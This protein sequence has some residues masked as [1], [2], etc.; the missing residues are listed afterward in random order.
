MKI[1]MKRPRDPVLVILAGVILLSMAVAAYNALFLCGG[2]INSEFKAY[3]LTAFS[4][5]TGLFAS[6]VALVGGLYAF[7]YY[8]NR[9]Q[10]IIG[11]VSPAKIDEYVVRGGYD[12]VH[13]R[14]DRLAPAIDDKLRPESL[15]SRLSGFDGGSMSVDHDGMGKLF[16]VFQNVGHRLAENCTVVVTFTEGVDLIDVETENLDID[17]FYTSAS[18][19]VTNRALLSAAPGPSIQDF[20][21]GL[22]GGK[23]LVQA[24]VRFVSSLEAFGFETVGVA[25]RVAKNV[26][27]FRIIYRCDCAGVFPH[28]EVHVQRVNVFTADSLMGCFLDR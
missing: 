9:P 21:G 6:I 22:L 5:V 10:L 4:S 23:P 16:F 15:D 3:P 25:I 19:L 14:A 28:R 12:E 13:F 1:G 11:L 8:R 2:S 20:Y 18:N 7:H 27:R 24:Y 26:D 17:G